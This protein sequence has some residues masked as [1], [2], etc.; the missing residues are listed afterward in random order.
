MNTPIEQQSLIENENPLYNLI[1]TKTT[2]PIHG[3][4]S[5]IKNIPEEYYNSEFIF[6][7]DITEDGK[8]RF[9]ISSSIPQFLIK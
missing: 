6:A 4:Y 5:S 2:E 7:E 3:P 9:F 1:T 8:T